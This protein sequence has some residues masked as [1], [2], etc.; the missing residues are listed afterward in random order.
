MYDWECEKCGHAFEEVVSLA[1][2]EDTDFLPCP[3]CGGNSP[4]VFSAAKL[5]WLNDKSRRN[6]ALQKRAAMDSQK[7]SEERA[8]MMTSPVEAT[9]SL[10]TK[11]G[12]DALMRAKGMK[13]RS[14]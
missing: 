5:H 1:E 11:K 2:L 9:G 4:R 10:M 12:Q 6:E 13:S 14:E 7:N 3:E 8:H